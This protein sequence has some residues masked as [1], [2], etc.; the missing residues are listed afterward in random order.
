MV[1]VYSDYRKY[2]CYGKY[3]NNVPILITIS[4]HLK[5]QNYSNYT[6]FSVKKLLFFGQSIIV[7][8]TFASNH[9]D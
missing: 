7:T 1:T 4:S 8:R 3:R 9:G 2:F 6:I 5:Y